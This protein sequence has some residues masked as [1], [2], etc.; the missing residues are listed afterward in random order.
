MFCKILLS[1]DGGSFAKIFE[2]FSHVRL[3]L[4]PTTNQI[5]WHCSNSQSV[6]LPKS[7][8]KH[9]K[10]MRVFIRTNF[11]REHVRENVWEL[12]KLGLISGYRPT[13]FVNEKVHS[14]I[15][16]SP[17]CKSPS[18]SIKKNLIYYDTVFQPECT[19]AWIPQKIEGWPPT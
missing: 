5:L 17:G 6:L 16:P 18:K 11:W 12:L 7:G 15:P 10:L 2:C 3:P 4:T 9:N 8:R 13:H 1:A 14:S 19:I